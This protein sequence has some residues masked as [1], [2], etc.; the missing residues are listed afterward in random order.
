MYIC[1]TCT[2]GF[3]N[4]KDVTKHSLKC[5]HKYNP[6]HESKSAPCKGNVTERQMNEDVNNFFMRFK[7]CQK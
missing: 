7:T 6:K 2:K 4:A 3:K 5:W 1:P